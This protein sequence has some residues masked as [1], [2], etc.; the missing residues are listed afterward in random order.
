[1]TVAVSKAGRLLKVRTKLQAGQFR[2]SEQETAHTTR[3]RA[4]RDCG[5]A[6]WPWLS[7]YRLG[8]RCGLALNGWIFGLI[9]GYDTFQIHL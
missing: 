9:I 6:G 2:P 8:D 5:P 3:R 4:G 1:M 7:G